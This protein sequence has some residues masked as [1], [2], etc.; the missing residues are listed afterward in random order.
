MH[1]NAV[2]A[3]YF[4]PLLQRLKARGYRF[5]DLD[6]VLEDPAYASEDTYT[7]RGGITWLHRWALTRRVDPSMFRGEPRTPEWVQEVAGIEE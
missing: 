2:N 1:A 4:E 6:S 7:G 3:D 5:V